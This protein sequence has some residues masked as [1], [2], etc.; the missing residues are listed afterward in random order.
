VST[1]I[2][3]PQSATIQIPTASGA[4]QP[5]PCLLEGLAGKRLTLTTLHHL[6]GSTP[7]AVECNDAMFLGE[8]VA[9]KCD[10]G[11]SWQMEIKVE[12]IL[13]GLQSLMT[14]RA[15]LLGEPVPELN[16]AGARR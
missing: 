4:R 1:S 12:Q 11:C 2:D 16:L 8:V 7:V 13:T 5:H 6:A 3:F 9:C 15:R 10:D 14:L